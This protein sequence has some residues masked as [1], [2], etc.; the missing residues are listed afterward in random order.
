MF[1]VRLTTRQITLPLGLKKFKTLAFIE[2]ST[3]S[4]VDQSLK[5]LNAIE[6]FKLVKV[7]LCDSMQLA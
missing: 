4:V 6:T 7:L 5:R 3:T 2:L 1:K